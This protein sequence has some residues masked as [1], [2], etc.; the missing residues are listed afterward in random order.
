MRAV[1]VFGDN[2]STGERSDGVNHK[3]LFYGSDCGEVKSLS[4]PVS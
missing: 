2:R 3:R 4:W 1:Q